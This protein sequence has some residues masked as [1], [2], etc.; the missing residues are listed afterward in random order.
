MEA[1]GIR[2]P[3]GLAYDA[4][5]EHLYVTMNQRDDLESAT[6]G[7]WLAIVDSGQA[8]G[9][10]DCYGQGGTACAGVPAPVAVLDPHAA[11]GGVAIVTGP[12]RDDRRHL[13]RSSRSGHSARSSGWRSTRAAGRERHGA[14]R[15]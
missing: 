9:F 11:V 8:W 6:P 12:A 10:P 13:A 5:G 14:A 1:T 4:L 2:A 7:D 15:S 3:V